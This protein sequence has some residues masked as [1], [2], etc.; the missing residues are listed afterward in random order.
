MLLVVIRTAQTSEVVA[1]MGADEARENMSK[2]HAMQRRRRPAIVTFYSSFGVGMGLIAGSLDSWTPDI[3]WLA[4]SVIL[5][6]L[7]PVAFLPLIK[8]RLTSIV[9]NNPATS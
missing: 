1:I 9:R 7:L 3:L 4:G 5:G 8:R 6:A 2:A